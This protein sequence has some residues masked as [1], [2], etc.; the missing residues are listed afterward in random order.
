MAFFKFRSG[1]DEPIAPSLAPQSVEA[2]R[3]RAKHR[4][5]GAAVLVAVGVVGF[6][7]IFDN[8]PR[9][10]PVDLPIS[11]PDK[12]TV[13]PL[14]NVPATNAGTAMIEETS[15]PDPSSV[16]AQAAS[17]LVTP[18]SSPSSSTPAKP[19]KPAAAVAPTLQAEAKP[20]A[21]SAKAAA[22]KTPEKAAEKPATEK[23]VPGKPVA[24]NAE[25]KG[26]GK[27]AQALLEGKEPFGPAAA[28]MAGASKPMPSASARFVVQVGAF[29]DVVKAREA[30]Q[31]LEGAG[32]KTYTQVITA[33]DGK[34]IRVRL[35]P[36]ESKADAD[37]AASKVKKLELPAAILE[38]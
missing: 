19:N 20:V 15:S 23:L 27:K 10:I 36:Y 1:G 8:Q 17:G 6:P 25:A 3:R 16:A 29:T 2:M 24:T 31:K 21:K 18:A 12:N 11:I 28:A 5:I 13:K 7:L 4:L 35:G 37:K 9:P 26:D 22:D 33:K 34:R 32:L 38:L 30:R 14:G